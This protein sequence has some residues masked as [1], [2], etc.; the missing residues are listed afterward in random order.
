MIAAEELRYQYGRH[1]AVQGFS[2][3]LAPGVI[4]LLGPNGAGKT[5]MLRILAGQLA[6]TS[7]V[8]TVAGDVVDSAALRSRLRE[9]SGYLPQ[10]PQWLPGFRVA[11]LVTYF[12][13]LR[14]P[15]RHVAGAVERALVVAGMLEFADRRL[16][17]LSGGERQRAFLAQSIVHDP[18]MLFLDEPTV[19]LDPVQ[20]VRLR[21]FI[22]VLG[23]ER[24]V[25]LSSHLIE[26]VEHL[27]TQVVV[28]DHGRSIWA[29]DAAEFR[30]YGARV[31]R[32]SPLQSQAESGLLAILD[33]NRTPDA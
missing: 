30:A 2:G 19:G 12:A 29:G 21:E 4:G 26:D 3:E 7:G 17:K 8:L 23:Q 18:E 16:G 32:G 5:T 9:R 15:R 20:R 24:L 25:V 1:V 14:L 27:A 31:R 6:P 11:E 10:D 22:A 13:K 33:E 28:M